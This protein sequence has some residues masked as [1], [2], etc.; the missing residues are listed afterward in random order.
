MP[1]FGVGLK[2]FRVA[3]SHTENYV[4]EFFNDSL[5]IISLGA[6]K[7]NANGFRKVTR[8]QLKFQWLLNVLQRLFCHRCSRHSI[9]LRP[10]IFRLGFAT[11]PST[12]CAT[13]IF[14][15]LFF[16]FFFLSDFFCTRIKATTFT[17]N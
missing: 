8:T 9:H 2:P 15:C 11:L 17:F 4:F 13:T 14:F 12:L 6:R 5:I 16:F 1:R 7:K 3:E 10:R